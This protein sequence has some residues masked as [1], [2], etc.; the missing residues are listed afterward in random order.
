[1][2]TYRRKTIVRKKN[3]NQEPSPHRTGD[4]VDEACGKDSSWKIEVSI[5]SDVNRL[6]HLVK[7]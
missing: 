4:L 1:M 2:E 3:L 7:I 6:S 5:R